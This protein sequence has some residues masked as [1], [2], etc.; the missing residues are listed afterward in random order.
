MQAYIF[1]ILQ[2][3]GTKLCNFTNFRKLFNAVVMN[4]T[5]FNIFKNFGYNAIGLFPSTEEFLLMEAPKNFF[6]RK[7]LNA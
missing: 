4:F 5:N 1:C 7:K 6:P 3:I 2:H